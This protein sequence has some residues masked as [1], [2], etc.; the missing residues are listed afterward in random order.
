MRS[1]RRRTRGQWQ[2]MV[3]DTEK[4]G[5]HTCRRRVPLCPRAL[6]TAGSAGH[7]A[8]KNRARKSAHSKQKE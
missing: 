2:D 5:E 3:V 1:R 6:S 4:E 8:P 7:A